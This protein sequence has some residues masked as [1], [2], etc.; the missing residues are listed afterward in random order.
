M[1]EYY[2]HYYPEEYKENNIGKMT[3][4]EFEKYL[5][6]KSIKYLKIFREF[7]N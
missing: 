6:D 4:E 5:A 7:I 1:K 3:S 2:R